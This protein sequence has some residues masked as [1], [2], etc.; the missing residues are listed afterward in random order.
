[1]GLVIQTILQMKLLT[2]KGP[3]DIE[4]LRLRVV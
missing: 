4:S 1:M 3:R 2:I